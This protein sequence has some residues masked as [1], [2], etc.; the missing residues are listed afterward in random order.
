MNEILR[1]VALSL[2]S[3]AVDVRTLPYLKLDNLE[4]P[5]AKRFAT[6]R[7]TFDF[8]FWPSIQLKSIAIIAHCHQLITP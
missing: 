7:D 5:K 8:D 4:V 3:L 2:S 6:Q 1:E